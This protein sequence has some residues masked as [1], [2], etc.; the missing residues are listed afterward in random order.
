MPCSASCLRVSTHISVA[1]VSEHSV[2]EYHHGFFLTGSRRVPR[3]GVEQR[4]RFSHWLPSD[5]EVRG[6][7]A[8]GN[9]LVSWGP[10]RIRAEVA[11]GDSLYVSSLGALL[12]CLVTVIIA[13]DSAAAMPPLCGLALGMLLVSVPREHSHG[14]A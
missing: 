9:L 13:S 3:T 8:V 11:V 2:I 1:H 7:G 10:A 12:I 5:F 14:P 4:S 6:E